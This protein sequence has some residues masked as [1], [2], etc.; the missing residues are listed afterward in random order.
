MSVH[1]FNGQREGQP[2]SVMMGYDRP[3]DCI[4]CTVFDRHNDVLYSNTND[5]NAGRSQ[6][7][8]SYFR[9]VL[10]K[11]QIAVP[12]TMFFEIASDQLR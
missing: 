11:L 8:A 7:S 2:V 3:L 6:Q 1:Y 10:S 5:P 12:E 4:H 9:T